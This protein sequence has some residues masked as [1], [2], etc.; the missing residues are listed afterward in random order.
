MFALFV[1]LIFSGYPV[2]WVLGGLAVFFT[3]IAV[4]AEADFGVDVGAD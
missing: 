1:L 2:A 3:A 4:I